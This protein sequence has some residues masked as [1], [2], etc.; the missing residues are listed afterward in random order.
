MYL[1]LLRPVVRNSAVYFCQVPT[2]G[3]FQHDTVFSIHSC[4]LCHSW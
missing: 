1:K 4:M 2:D 3:N